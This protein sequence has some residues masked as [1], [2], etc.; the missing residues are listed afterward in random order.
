MRAALSVVIPA[1]NAEKALPACLAALMEGLEAG[2][3][4]ELVVSDGGSG[5]A[6]VRIA[7]EVGAIVLRGP[8]SRG[9]QLRCGVA[10]AQGDWVMLLHADTVLEPGWSEAVIAHMQTGGAGYFRLGFRAQGLAATWVAGWANR[11]ARW[12]GLPYGDQGLVV[13]RAVLEAAGGV[14]DIPLME[15]VA[16][17]RALRGQLRALPVT[18]RTSAERYETEGWFRRGRRNLWLLCRYLCGADPARLEQDYRR[19][20]RRS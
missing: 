14:P 9:G 20:G 1:L 19:S 10:A 12:F 5:D 8:A 11:R 13:P 3:I 17:V 7:E 16:L 2:L 6:T 4:R 18:A 15:D